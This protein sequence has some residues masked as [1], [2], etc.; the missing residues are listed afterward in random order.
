MHWRQ[1]Y[2]IAIGNILGSNIFNILLVLG[3][4]ALITPIPINKDILY[5]DYAVMLD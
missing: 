3:L 5:R 2:D 1:E 4:P